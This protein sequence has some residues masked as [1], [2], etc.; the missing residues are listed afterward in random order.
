MGMMGKIRS[1]SDGRL[2]TVES[3]GGSGG[4][5][6]GL[7]CIVERRGEPRRR[8]EKFYSRGVG[9][10]RK[11]AGGHLYI[12]QEGLPAGGRQGEGEVNNNERLPR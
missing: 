7:L 10:R 4:S 5:N 9:G 1:T 8:I 2:C 12:G 11:R 3:P 6:S